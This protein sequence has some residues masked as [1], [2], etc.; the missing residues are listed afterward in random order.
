VLTG[1]EYGN[2]YDHFSVVYEYANGVKLY[3]NSCQHPRCRSDM[4]AHVAGTKGRA[5]FS[6]RKHGLAIQANGDWHY[7]WPT[8]DVC[9]TGTDRL[10]AAIRAGK[11]INNGAY[12]AKSSLL[13]IM[14]RMAVYTGQQIAGEMAL[15]SKE[16]LAPPSYDWNV[17]LPVPAVSMPGQT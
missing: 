6:D 2:I 10:L 5:R 11:P 9:Q 4:S 16:D 1:P 8:N 13:A 14:G 17:R 3:S 7:D 12:M 15:T